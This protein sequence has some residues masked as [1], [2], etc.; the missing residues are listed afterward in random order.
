MSTNSNAPIPAC[1][2]TRSHNTTDIKTQRK[3]DQIV[4]GNVTIKKNNDGF[5]I[6]FSKI[7]KM[8]IYQIWS[9]K[10]ASIDKKRN[11]KY[12]KVKDWIKKQF[13]K[14]E[15]IAYTPTCVMNLDNG[16]RYVFVINK[17]KVNKHDKVVFY[18]SSQDIS[19]PSNSQLKSLKKIPQ[20]NFTNVRFDIDSY[21]GWLQCSN[22]WIGTKNLLCNPTCRL[23]CET[24]WGFTSSKTQT[25]TCCAGCQSSITLNGCQPYIF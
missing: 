4:R 8:L 3:Y 16:K 13:E 22:I 6:T 18:V 11:V 25:A 17:A 15:N 7:S 21:P 2:S 19:L 9:N 14:T 23:V 1:S 20:G 5:K 12:V 24:F 10:D